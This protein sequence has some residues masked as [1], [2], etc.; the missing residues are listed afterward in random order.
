MNTLVMKAGYK[1]N[2]GKIIPETSRGR[3]LYTV[4]WF[5]NGSPLLRN[6]DNSSRP[7]SLSA[8]FQDNHQ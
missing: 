7:A 6:H 8:H 5:L 3:A 1:R 2:Q 4:D